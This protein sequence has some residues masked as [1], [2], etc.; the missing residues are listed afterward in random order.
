MT[1]LDQEQVTTALMRYSKVTKGYILYDLAN[2]S[3]FVNK[4]VTFR[5]NMFLFKYISNDSSKLFLNDAPWLM[6]SENTSHIEDNYHVPELDTPFAA[7]SE[8][9]PD[10]SSQHSELPDL[11]IPASPT[12]ESTD[13][14]PDTIPTDDPILAPDSPLDVFNFP[15]PHTVVSVPDS[16]NAPL[17][18]S[19]RNKQ[20]PTWMIDF[21][22]GS[23]PKSTTQPPHTIHASIAYDRLKPSYRQSLAASISIVEPQTFHEAY[24]DPLWIDAMQTELKA[25][26]DNK[27]WELDR[28]PPSKVPIGCKWVYKVKYK[29]K[30]DVEGYKVR[31]VAKRYSQQEGLDYNETFALV[32]KIVIVRAVMSLATSEGSDMSLIEST[33]QDLQQ[34]FKMKD[35]DELKYFLGIEFSRSHKGILMNQIK[36][37]L[38][39]IA[40]L[41]LSAAKPIGTPLEFNQKLTTKDLDEV[42]GTREDELLEDKLQYQRLI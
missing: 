19:Q 38:D 28:L 25:L 23:N 12:G 16:F 22:I 35:L 9:P 11:V 6:S 24:I 31:L 3:F 21:I 42:A 41:G 30:G 15:H 10:Q 36:Y 7:D 26:E 13:H 33:K 40:N 14:M 5:E 8:V 39:L 20:Q 4:D 29:A 34:A 32:G 37:T 18:Q 2:H 1:N 17:R 27:T